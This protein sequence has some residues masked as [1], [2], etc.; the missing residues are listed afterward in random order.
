MLLFFSFF[1]REIKNCNRS[2]KVR[3]IFLVLYK[4]LVS[5]KV[6]VPLNSGS[7]QLGICYG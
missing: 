3:V 5:L 1:G 6:E 4:I 2:L 7:Q